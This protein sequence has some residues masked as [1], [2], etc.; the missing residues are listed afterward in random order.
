MSM[1]ATAC[2]QLI[3]RYIRPAGIEDPGVLR[4]LQAIPR[5]WF[6]DP[7]LATRAYQNT[8]LPIGYGQT[9]SQPSMVARMTQELELG[10][11]E[12]VLEI[13]TGSGYQ[14]AIL[15]QLATC[16][17]SI[18][19]IPEL[20]A[21]A[22]MILERLNI[23]NVYLKVS[24]GTL[25]AESQTYDRIMV[26]AGGNRQPDSLLRQL[27]PGGILLIPIGDAQHQTLYKY[28]RTGDNQFDCEALVGCSFVKLIGKEGWQNEEDA[29]SV[30]SRQIVLEADRS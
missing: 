10:G 15:S 1:Y 9:I 27:R 28:R 29:L 11:S 18:E 22:S 30:A 24:D 19:R 8:A 2:R 26:T 6:V 16:V 17:H 20:T 3:D 14:A 4:A 5:H 7:A 13:G 25:G 21:R 23:D 12:Q